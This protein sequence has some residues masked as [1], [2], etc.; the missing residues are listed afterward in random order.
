MSCASGS[1]KLSDAVW[2]VV[3]ESANTLHRLTFSKQLAQ[4]IVDTIPGNYS[5]RKFHYRLRDKLQ[6]NEKSRNGLYAIVSSI[7]QDLVLRIGLSKEVSE[8]LTQDDSRY[9]ANIELMS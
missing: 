3:D 8:L 7:K 4:H 5:L 2:G 9:L 6:S 1:C